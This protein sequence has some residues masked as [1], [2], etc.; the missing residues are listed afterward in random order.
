MNGFRC[1][2]ALI[3]GEIRS[4]VEI[5][6][7]QGLITAIG[8]AGGVCGPDGGGCDDIQPLPGL[9]LPGFADAH[10]HVFH[11]ALR[12]R[13]HT[14]T[15]PAGSGSFWTWREQMYA[16]ADRLDPESLFE[17]ARAAYVEMVCAGV[18]A[19]G[20][21]HYLHHGPGGVPYADRNELGLT[22]LRA[23]EQAG[24][25][26]T[27]LDVAYLRGG[28]GNDSG[29][30]PSQRRFSDGSV[31]AWAE[32][33]AALPAE[34]RTGVAI[35][36]VRAVAPA[37]LPTVAAVA[38]ASGR[39]LH[40][41][42]SE[43]PA[44]NAACLAATGCTPTQLLARSGAITPATAAVHATHLST[45]DIETLGA[46]KAFVV[47]CPATEADLADGLPRAGALARAGA[48]LALGSDQHVVT[49]PFG[50]ARGLEW[51]ERLA[52]GT[53]G[54]FTPQRLADVAT[55]VS[56]DAIGSPS[57]RLEVG[58]PADLVEIDPDSPRTAG[59]LGLG[60]MMSATAADVLTVVVGGTVLAR[61][62]RHV[63]W[64]EPGPLLKRA[65]EG[66]WGK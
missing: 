9:V 45:A 27:L 29:L 23:A 37:D 63:R 54:H 59:S 33:V 60:L 20:E 7:A 6:C 55:A 12:G 56:H 13:T 2:R 32:R 18:T 19:V 15:G 34:A 16:L 4:D 28:F 61:G 40:V 39:P 31:A 1:G 50:Q 35:H 5:H 10:S 17:L 46:A 66:V 24:P 38:T 3:A 57:G 26:L 41:H 53:R 52:T 47:V 65:I 44:E 36:S 48:R 43:Q 14:G 25:V 58:A 64:G 62:G 30:S 11:R 42:L 22:L 21:F 51:G 8:P 49:D